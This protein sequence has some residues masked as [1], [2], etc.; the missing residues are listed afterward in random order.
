MHVRQF[1][2]DCKVMANPPIEL[3][4]VAWLLPANNGTTLRN[5][6]TWNGYS[7]EAW[8]GHVIGSNQ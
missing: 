1:K 6:E 8:V 7:V 4:S 3:A 5:G 2:V